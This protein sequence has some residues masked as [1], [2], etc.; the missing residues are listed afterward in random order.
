MVRSQA[1][2]QD[3][4][5]GGGEEGGEG[6]GEVRVLEKRPKAFY[7]RLSVAVN[8]KYTL[9]TQSQALCLFIID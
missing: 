8:A 6:R 4:F 2:S 9:P 7:Q 5:F 3:F 1:R